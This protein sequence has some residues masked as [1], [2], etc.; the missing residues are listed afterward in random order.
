MDE[1]S[2][3]CEAFELIKQNKFDLATDCISVYVNNLGES[4]ITTRTVQLVKYVNEAIRLKDQE[5]N[6]NHLLSLKNS[7]CYLE[8]YT[9]DFSETEYEIIEDKSKEIWWCWLQ[10]IE[11]APPLVKACLR[12]VEMLGDKVNIVTAENFKKYIHVPDYI[13]D[14]W[15]KGHISNAHFSDILRL[16]LLSRYGGTWIDSTVLFTG[17][18]QYQM[19]REQNLFVYKHLMRGSDSQFILASNWLIHSN[20]KSNIVRLTKQYLLDYWKNEDKLINYFI[21]HMF[22]SIACR[23]NA[24]EWK[25]VPSFSNVPCHI[26]Q[27]EMLETYSPDRW[28]QLTEMTDVHKLTYKFSQS[29]E[30]S[31]ANYIIQSIKEN[32]R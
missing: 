16:E 10:G 11:N 1:F 8:K 23:K 31:F 24:T 29:N 2:V 12:S 9:S 7:Y 14:K 6:L 27:E 5:N 3:F 4:E 13:L 19:I 28:K 32:R 22:F 15:E 30:D 17:E 18:K 21:F 20:G 25:N 26:M